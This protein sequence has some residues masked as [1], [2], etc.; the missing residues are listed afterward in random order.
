MFIPAYTWVSVKNAGT[1]TVGLVFVFSAPGF[2]NLMR[3]TNQCCQTKNRYLFPLKNTKTAI[4]KDMSSTR[5][6][7]K[8][9]K[10][11]VKLGNL[12][13]SLRPAVLNS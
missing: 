10:S 3:C 12:R 6:E 1:E 9:P 13:S 2:E 4:T 5:I 11:E 8:A 7:K